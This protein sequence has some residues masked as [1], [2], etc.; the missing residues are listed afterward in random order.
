[1]IKNKTFVNSRSSRRDSENVE[2]KSKFQRFVVDSMSL[3]IFAFFVTFILTSFVTI[4]S[5]SF[6]TIVFAFFVTLLSFSASLDESIVN[7][8]FEK[9]NRDVLIR[10][11]TTLI[12]FL[13]HLTNVFVANLISI[14]IAASMINSVVTFAF[15]SIIEI[16]FE[17]LNDVLAKDQKR[18]QNLKLKMMNHEHR[19]V[20]DDF[21][22]YSCRVRRVIQFL[23][24]FAI[25]HCLV[26]FLLSLF[27]EF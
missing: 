26:M 18:R 23:L 9:M 8:I 15:Q 14:Q 4:V 11:L 1:M 24:V 19:R 25:R 12:S 21:F 20:I 5:T 17:N 2:T 6:V 22:F 27:F 13:A 10:F 16:D 7:S 3:I